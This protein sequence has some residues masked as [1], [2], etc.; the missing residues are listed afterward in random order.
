LRILQEWRACD[1]WAKRWEWVWRASALGAGAARLE[2][3]ALLAGRSI[4]KKRA[5]VLMVEAGA[6]HAVESTGVPIRGR[7]N[8]TRSSRPKSEVTREKLCR[9]TARLLEQ[10]PLLELKIADITNLA[11]VAPSTF[12]IY[13]S[14]MNDAALGALEAV[15][16]E[17]PDLAAHV[18]GMTRAN[19]RRDLNILLKEY[20]AFWEQHYAILRMRNLAA[21]EGDKR[22]REARARMLSPMVAAL[23]DKITEFRG[24]SP[25]GAAPLA[26]AILLSGAMERLASITRLGPVGPQVT[27]RRLIEAMVLL[28]SEAILAPGEAPR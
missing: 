17:A 25:G 6:P 27:R 21:D 5:T 18:R 13:F 7:V 26:L 14:D 4:V 3:G 2:V 24:P 12:Y 19:M 16:R 1:G 8:A 28:M 10:K 22:F 23:G 15:E 9:A 20:L 11:S